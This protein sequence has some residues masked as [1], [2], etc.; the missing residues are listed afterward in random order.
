MNGIFSYENY[1]NEFFELQDFYDVVDS[2]VVD[3]KPVEI[4]EQPKKKAK[5]SYAVQIGELKQ[6]IINLRQE[7][8]IQ[9]HQMLCL[10]GE[11]TK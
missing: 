4:V 5:K 8:E 7:I 1:F 3:V 9:N 10:I 11:K 6:E 2:L